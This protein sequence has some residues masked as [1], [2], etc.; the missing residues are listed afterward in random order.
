[1][2]ATCTHSGLSNVYV[3]VCVWV[4][5]GHQELCN[6][7][8][9]SK[10]KARRF[11]IH[12]PVRPSGKARRINVSLSILIGMVPVDDTSASGQMCENMCLLTVVICA[13]RFVLGALCLPTCYSAAVLLCSCACL[14]LLVSGREDGDRELTSLAMKQG[15][16]NRRHNGSLYRPCRLN[17]ALRYTNVFFLSWMGSS[18][19][20]RPKKNLTGLSCK[21]LYFLCFSGVRD[22]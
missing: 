20:V 22:S 16:E 18:D 6:A 4:H 11:N 5:L 17:R 1:M 14:V 19:A 3:R 9:S 2:A 15:E 8:A 12:L 13:R 7:V 21:Q 10:H